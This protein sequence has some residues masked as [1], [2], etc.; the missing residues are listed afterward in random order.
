MMLGNCRAFFS[1]RIDDARISLIMYVFCNIV[2]NIDGENG[3]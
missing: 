3:D 1:G 2:H